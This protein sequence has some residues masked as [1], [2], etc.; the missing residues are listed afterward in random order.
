[1]RVNSGRSTQSASERGWSWRHQLQVWHV[2]AMA[3]VQNPKDQDVRRGRGVG[4]KESLQ[5]ELQA[6]GDLITD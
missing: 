3:A 4:K 1:M 5:R 6:I 2:V